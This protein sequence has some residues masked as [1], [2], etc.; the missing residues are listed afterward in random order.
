V[1]FDD[2]ASGT[3]TINIAAADVVPAA[4]MFTTTASLYK[5]TSSGGFGIAGSQ[6]L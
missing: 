4:T 6:H 3:R 5:L 2:S 1:L